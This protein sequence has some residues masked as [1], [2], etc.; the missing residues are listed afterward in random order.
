M[1]PYV[2]HA[3]DKKNG[4]ILPFY[5]SNRCRF[6][7]RSSESYADE[8][9]YVMIAISIAIIQEKY[10]DEFEFPVR[11]RQDFMDQGGNQISIEEKNN[12]E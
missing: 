5:F 2:R 12:S 9:I 10:R 1:Y 7:K 11:G 8:E 3:T 6:E 4:V